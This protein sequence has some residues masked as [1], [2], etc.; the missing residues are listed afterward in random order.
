MHKTNAMRLLD[1]AGIPYETVTYS[2]SEDDLSGVHAAEQIKSITPAQC[3]KTIVARGDRNHPLVFC[4]PVA[5]EIDLKR[6]ASESGQKRV[7]L[8]HV[9]ELRGLTGYL[10]G[11]CSPV[12]MKK[13]FPTFIDFSAAAFDKIGV[14]GGLRGVQVILDP[15]A[16]A[17][18][19]G[20]KFCRLTR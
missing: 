1:A 9:S 12:G 3:F 16:L 7:A 4:I 20:A 14:S 6:A 18:F 13:D 15:H 5:E 10:R 17:A 8:I 2:Y 11:G 19:I